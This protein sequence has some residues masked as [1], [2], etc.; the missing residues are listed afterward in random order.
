LLSHLTTEWWL[1]DRRQV[2]QAKQDGDD[3]TVTVPP[4]TITVTVTAPPTARTPAASAMEPQSSGYSTEGVY[5][6]GTAPS[7]GLQAAIPQGRYRV[8]LRANNAVPAGGWDRRN[9]YLC[10]PSYLDNVIGSGNVTQSQLSLILEI[11]PTD[12]A[13][14]LI[15]VTLRRIG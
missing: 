5:A 2:A 10:G 12:V 9:S 6:V 8:E 14:Y 7:G 11:E 4:S 1:N 13:M 3:N 15:G